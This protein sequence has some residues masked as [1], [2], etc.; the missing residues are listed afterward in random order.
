MDYQIEQIEGIT[1]DW[2]HEETIL[3][4]KFTTVKRKSLQALEMTMQEIVQH[5]KPSTFRILIDFSE[6]NFSP[7]LRKISN[8]VT[9]LIGEK[10]LTGRRAVVV[11]S[12][13]LGNLVTNWAQSVR[14]NDKSL[15][16]RIFK[17]TASAYE[18]LKE[19]D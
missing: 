4:V 3:H 18:W 11:P 2:L 9:R 13:V 12:G 15:D 16:T 10:S 14:R 6:G 7:H 19:T 17:D 5:W 8:L 1:F